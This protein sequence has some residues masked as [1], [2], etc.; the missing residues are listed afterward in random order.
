MDLEQAIKEMK[1]HHEL[2][3]DDDHYSDDDAIEDLMNECGMTSDGSCT[4]AGSEYCD[5]EC[6]FSS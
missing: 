4:M 6:P 3:Y 2:N 1:E 5:W